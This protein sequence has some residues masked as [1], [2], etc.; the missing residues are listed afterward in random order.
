MVQMSKI[1]I[2]GAPFGLIGGPGMAE[3]RRLVPKTLPHSVPGWDASISCAW[4]HSETSTALL[5]PPKGPVSAQND[6]FWGI[7]Q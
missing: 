1:V 6:P 2:F 7:G 4:A 3:M 5:G